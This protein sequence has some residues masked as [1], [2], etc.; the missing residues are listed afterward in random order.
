M[1]LAGLKRLALAVLYLQVHHAQAAQTFRTSLSLKDFREQLERTQNRNALAR[2]DVDLSKLYPEHNIS[3]PIDHFNNDSSYEPH[4][5]GFFNLRYWFDASHYKPGGP[6]IV[7]QSG[8]TSGE[9]RLPYLQKG[10]VAQLS[11]ATN[12]LG[13]ILEHR[14]YGTSFPVPDLST[15][16]MRFLTTDQALAD[17][18]YFAQNVVFEGL[19][20]LN[21]TSHKNAYI[22]YGGSYAGAFVAILRKQ[23]PDVYWG[24]ISSSGVT[25]A[26]YDYWEYFVAAETYG[27][28]DCITA[29]QKLTNVI[30]NILIGK[31]GTD[32]PQRLKTAFG[33][34]GITRSNDFANSINGGIYALQSTNWDPAE[35]S[36][37]YG[38]YCNN[39]S[40]ADAL[41]PGLEGIRTEVHDLIVA[42]GYADE[43]DS[44]LNK[45][46]NY[47]GYV[48]ST[49]VAPC[50]K[51]NVSQD[52][53]FTNY[54]S[55]FYEQ[56]DITQD[57]RSW[58]YQYC[59]Q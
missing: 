6:V 51:R 57:W 42:G 39:V 7:L 15:E 17:M 35:N 27:P 54:N 16:N 24:A 48:N 19:E 28:K 23:Y 9:D 59:T 31:N 34:G 30:D 4:S 5:D 26:I 11:Q 50:Q 38:L 53:C 13:V 29:T 55:T 14:Y 22:A 20:H 45:M 43:V 2:R 18:A 58:P 10:I 44:L 8:E 25:E 52:A 1:L 49:V 12:G 3:V 37:D 40:S 47:I 21:L 32:Y 56:D 36:T 46:L 41:Y 33:L